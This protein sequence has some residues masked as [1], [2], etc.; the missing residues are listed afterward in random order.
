MSTN[1]RAY[2]IDQISSGSST[3]LMNQA[4]TDGT[5]VGYRYSGSVEYIVNVGPIQYNST[6]ST[7]LPL[8]KVWAVMKGEFGVSGSLTL[9][10]GGTLNLGSLD[11][12]QI[13]PCYPKSLVVSAGSILLLS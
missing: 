9:E 11:N 7:G 1:F 5:A 3:I 12:H 10:G 6:G 8:D 4:G 2:R 13:F